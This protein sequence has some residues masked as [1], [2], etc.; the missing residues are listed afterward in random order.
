[1]SESIEDI[2]HE[3][4][5]LI[6]IIEGASAIADK[7]IKNNR[8]ND[9]ERKIYFEMIERNLRRMRDMFSALEKIV[10]LNPNRK[11]SLNNGKIRKPSGH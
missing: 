8:F 2:K 3:W 9:E 5:S 1:M 7:K 4:F 11:E 6:A 10:D